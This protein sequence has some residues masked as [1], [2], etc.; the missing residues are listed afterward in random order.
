LQCWHFRRAEHF[1]GKLKSLSC[2]YFKLRCRDRRKLSA[3][4][5]ENGNKTEQNEEKFLLEPLKKIL[6]SQ[7]PVLKP[8]SLPDSFAP[9]GF[10]CPGVMIPFFPVLCDLSKS[11]GIVIFS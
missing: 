9:S 4:T 6:P 1:I 3:A 2:R 11:L 8:V 10:C 5:E 7:Y